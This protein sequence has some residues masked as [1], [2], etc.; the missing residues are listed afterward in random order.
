[1]VFLP[2]KFHGQE[3]VGLQ[4]MGLDAKVGQGWAHTHYINLRCIEN[5][6]TYILQ[7]D[8]HSNVSQHP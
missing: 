3:P 5:D 6:L 2:G 1:M 8:N 7:N 4:S